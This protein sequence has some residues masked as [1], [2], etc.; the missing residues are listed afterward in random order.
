MYKDKVS[1]RDRLY[2]LRI[3]D[4]GEDWG[5]YYVGSTQLLAR[6]VN[7]D[8]SYTCDEAHAVDEMIFYFVPAHYFKFSDS[9]MRQQILREIS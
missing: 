9:R 2:N 3:V 8:Q 6:L 7:D 4:F 1:F 5:N